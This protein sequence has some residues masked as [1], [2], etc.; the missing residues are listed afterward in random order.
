MQGFEIRRCG[1]DELPRLREFIRGHWARDHI[2]ARDRGLLAWQHVNPYSSE[3]NYLVAESSGE[4]VGILG[5]I[6]TSRFDPALADR[7]MYW[8]ALWK[9]REDVA[10][11]GLGLRLLNRLISMADGAPVSVVGIGN[12]QHNAIYRALGFQVG[13]LAH[14]FRPARNV[15]QRHIAP[16]PADYGQAS[17]LA[18]SAKLLE[19]N[20]SDLENI[21]VHLSERARL[22]P[23]KSPRYFIERFLKHPRY[24]YRV[25]RVVDEGKT[26][27]LVASR[28]AWA[29][30]RS[31]S[32]GLELIPDAS[33]LRI[34]DLWLDTEVLAKCGPALDELLIQSG[35]EYL[36]CFNYGIAEDIFRAAGL[37]RVEPEGD[38]HIPNYLEP[39]SLS[40]RRIHFSFR[41]DGRDYI[42]CRADGDQDRP[43]IVSPT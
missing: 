25:H 22:A 8:I 21:E 7:D 41:P 9:V 40:G 12:V 18:G 24:R 17:M 42:I 36:D 4:L 43:N 29:W 32:G 31:E 39:I 6:R 26:R 20:V 33:V 30:H 38:I 34:V 1:P 13:E 27:G 37:T 16:L 28:L 19:A 2:L 11:P 14:F 10:V 3:C 15:L 5:F 35:A 23:D